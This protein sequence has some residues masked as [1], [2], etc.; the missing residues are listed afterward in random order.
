[1]TQE[2]LCTEDDWYGCYDSS[3]RDDV[4]YR[5]ARKPKNVKGKGKGKPADTSMFGQEEVEII[6]RADPTSHPAKMSNPLC[7]RIIEEMLSRGWLKPGALL[8]DPFGGTGKTALIW[9]GRS[10]QNRAVSNEIEGHF[11]QMQRDVKEQSE[12]RLG[13]PLRWAIL[14]G[15]SR[16]LHELLA[17]DMSSTRQLVEKERQ[18]L[19]EQWQS[20]WRAEAFQPFDPWSGGLGYAAGVCGKPWV[21]EDWPDGDSLLSEAGVAVGSPPYTG[22]D[23]SDY[24]HKRRDERRLGE[25]FSGHG[26]GC[27]RGSE[28]YGREPGNIGNLPD[29]DLP[30]VAVGSPPYAEAQTGGG[31][32]H[33]GTP[34]QGAASG[35]G[36]YRRDAHG[37]TEGNIGNLK[38]AEEPPVAFGSPPY[39]QGTIGKT[40]VEKLRRLTQDP[41]SSLYGRDP[42]GAWFQAMAAGYI[43]SQGNIDNCLDVTAIGSP[44]YLDRDPRRS[45]DPT[46]T[47]VYGQA[48]GQIGSLPDAAIG[49]PPYATS[50]HH[51]NG[52]DAEKLT[53]N[54]PGPNS[55]WKAEGYGD[56]T[57]QIG[58][59]KDPDALPSVALG[60][61]P[62]EAQSGGTRGGDPNGAIAS[63]GL[64]ERHAASNASLGYA[65]VGSPPYE[66]QN[67]D[68]DYG[69]GLKIGNV[70]RGHRDKHTDALQDG[71]WSYGTSNGQIGTTEGE[72]YASAMA[73]VFQSM[74]QAGIR[75]TCMVTKNPT[76]NG[77]LREL[78]VLTIR[79]LEQA[80]YRVVH[81]VR[82]WLFHT[83]E[84]IESLAGQQTL[85]G[86]ELGP[87]KRIKG[88]ISFF[89]RI[90]IGKGN[91][92]AQWEDILF[93][94]LIN[95]LG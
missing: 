90:Q 50:I 25:G 46:L 9:C 23:K 21:L 55:Q 86:E 78:D 83:Q 71:G 14:R 63:A 72:T 82:A 75:Y 70:R 17:G 49:S 51:G 1:M 85:L 89:K 11:V 67:K 16:K 64:Q 20:D 87:S 24:T 13:R 10:P 3:S 57:G 58:N 15:D 60:S 94:E 8:C 79:L 39:G 41:T 69:K 26:R 95:P 48:E 54:T 76:R 32:C 91:V 37:E 47:G 35:T 74:A 77:K 30:A 59:L 5:K 62:Y 68:G 38:D 4:L 93:S 18:A 2:H 84:Q 33:T 80:G 42:D 19:M 28:N 53:G 44:P 6:K 29:R 65:A 66:D 45:G 43:N 56:T 52:I 12:H 73:A 7:E 88:R 36:G 22:N 81:R 31:I 40:D 27:F 61:P 34:H 92:A